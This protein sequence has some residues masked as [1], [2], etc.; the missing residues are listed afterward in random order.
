MSKDV[1]IHFKEPC[2]KNEKI[3]K[4]KYFIAKAEVG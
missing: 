1:Q 2:A 4:Y 3:L